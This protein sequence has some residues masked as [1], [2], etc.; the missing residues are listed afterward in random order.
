[1]G[2]YNSRGFQFVGRY[3]VPGQPDTNTQRP[4]GHQS[5]LPIRQTHPGCFIPAAPR[6]RD[7]RVSP[8]Q[9][10]PGLQREQPLTPGNVARMSRTPSTAYG[11][12]PAFNENV[13][14]PAHYQDRYRYLTPS[15]SPRQHHD[16]E[17]E[18][19]RGLEQHEQRRRQSNYTH[20][21]PAEE[22]QSR[23]DGYYGNSAAMADFYGASR[24]DYRDARENSPRRE[25]ELACE[26]Y[27]R[28]YG[29]NHHTPS[30]SRHDS[31]PRYSSDRR[32]DN[33]GGGRRGGYY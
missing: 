3:G 21:T 23:A 24:R 5:N 11:P 31:V 16:T 32:H 29:Y 1:M 7:P 9:V 30:D 19:Y 25:H 4:S 18:K 27:R 10:S 12:P 26:D 2:D 20:E 28:R 8:P 6:A 22:R 33:Y 17:F 14:N 13:F 15:L